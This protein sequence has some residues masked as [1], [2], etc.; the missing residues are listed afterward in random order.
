MTG[1]SCRAGSKVRATPWTSNPAIGLETKPSAAAPNLTVMPHLLCAVPS[2]FEAH[3]IP[4]VPADLKALEC[5]RFSFSGH[6]DI[7]EF[8][9]GDRIEK[10]AVD[11][12]YSMASSLA[13][14]DALRAGFGASLMPRPYVEDDLRQGLLQPALDDWC[15]VETT[16]YVVYSSR[17]H[18]APKVR[19]FLAFLVDTFG[20][21]QDAPVD[22][23]PT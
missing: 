7:W 4:R 21:G 9:N 2:Y 6:A 12:R 18:V 16:L 8:R 15:A 14:R 11:A 10:I 20:S 19:A 13:V 5:I 23:S 3:G 1:T 17:Q 22:E